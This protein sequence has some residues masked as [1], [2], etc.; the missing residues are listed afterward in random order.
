MHAREA[1]D[2]AHGSATVAAAEA[3][4]PTTAADAAYT[5]HAGVVCCVT[6]ADCLPVLLADPQGRVVGVA[7]AGWRGLAAG[8]VQNTVR[9]M[10]AAIGEPH[11][12]LHA[13][14]GPAIGSEAFVVGADVQAAMRAALPGADAAFVAHGG[15]K[16]RADLFALCKMALLAVGVTEVSGGGVSTAADPRRFYSHRRDRIS[17]RHAALIWR[18]TEVDPARV[19]VGRD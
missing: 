14:L 18:A 8:V 5:T 13:W 11:A 16:F 1:A 3:V 9:A 19:A 6:M 12:A 17:G 7:H 2:P 4:T 15:A 10:R